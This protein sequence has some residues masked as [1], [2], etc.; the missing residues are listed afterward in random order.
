MQEF[1]TRKAIAQRMDLRLLNCLFRKY[2]MAVRIM[3]LTA[4]LLAACLQLSARGLTQTVTI[5]VKDVPLLTVLK[6][7]KKQTGFV[8]Y[9][10]SEELKR[11]KNV[12]II[13]NNLPLEQVLDLCFKD[14]PLTYSITGKLINI[15]PRIEQVNK[16]NKTSFTAPLP[17]SIDVSGKVM[18]ENGGP[19]AGANVVEKGKQHGTTTNNEGVFVLKGVDENGS[20]EIS[21]IGYQTLTVPINNRTSII[22]SIKQSDASLQEVVINKGYYT[23]QKKLAT[24]NVST[25]KAKDIEMQPVQNPLLTL[26]GRVPGIIVEQKNGFANGGIVVRIQGRNSINSGLD[27][28]YVID[29]V[30]YLSQSLPTVGLSTTVLGNS[31]GGGAGNPLNFINPNDIESI[32]VLKDADATAIYGSRGAN[33]VILITTKKGKAEQ[34]KVSVNARTGWGRVSK[35]VKLLNI[36]QYFEMRKEAYV[37]DGLPIPDKTTIPDNTNYDLTYWDQNRLTDWQKVLIG[38]TAQYKDAQ[39]SVSGGSINTQFLI[40]GGYHKE[41]TVFPDDFADKKASF[42]F[43]INHSSNNQKFKLQA[44]GFYIK[45]DNKIP[46]TDITIYA[47]GLAPNAPALYNPDG[48]L[49]WAPIAQGSGTVSTWVNPL[50]YLYDKYNNKVNN[51]LG[52]A[53]FSYRIFPNLTFSSRFGFNNLQSNDQ[54]LVSLLATRPERQNANSRFAMYGNGSSTSWIVEP[55]LT[56]KIFTGKG[57]IETLLGSSVQQITTKSQ[58]VQA[59]GFSSDLLLEN[60]SSASSLA[61]NSSFYSLYKYNAIFGRV[62]YNY[63]DRYIINFTAR[64]DGSSRFGP[65]NL[66]HN[67]WGIAG[68]WIFTNENWI[69][70]RNS[71]LNFGKVRISY[72][73]T[74]NDQ[75]GD[76]SFMNLYNPLTSGVGISY[77]GVSAM[78]P[79]KLSNPYLQWEETKKLQFGID[80]GLMNDRIIVNLNYYLNRSSNLLAESKVAYITGF[81]S[82]IQNLDGVVE[83]RGWEIS[84]SSINIRKDKF[85]W[86]TNFNVTIPTKNGQLTSF[87]SLSKTNYANTLVVGKS[88]YDTKSYHFIGV[89]PATGLYKYNDTQGNST[90]SPGAKD[91]IA[92]T[93]TT[94]KLYGGLQNNLTYKGVGLDFTFQFVKR[95]AQKFTGT[96]PGIFWGTYNQG[97]QP[98]RVLQRW[99]HPGDLTNV[100]K[101]SSNYSGA[102]SDAEYYY[103]IS[104]AAVTNGSF[105]QLTNLSLSWQFPKL[106]MDKVHFQNCKLF[107][108]GQNL[109]IATKYKGLYPPIGGIVSA[110]PATTLPPL[111]VITI[112]GQITF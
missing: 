73:T 45:D 66:F 110:S 100:E 15:I 93:N 58:S 71:F 37:N 103:S 35:K 18:D 55:Q 46:S 24:G 111:R 6:A 86:V 12:S 92:F 112:G 104:D 30:P 19:L 50:S 59:F 20:L 11:A 107:I 33:G 70:K 2:R 109:F 76:Y 39:I 69:S 80:F 81:N 42:Q 1:A 28:L 9:V 29:G 62:N 63:K 43:N 47:L 44:S 106:W 13:A 10:T 79:T 53:V 49:N 74:G 78:V 22:I 60:L 96:Q 34:T 84:L 41:T 36:D 26:I 85:S 87:P 51:F 89:D 67:F 5:S 77:Q 94:Q 98:E 32:D 25:V 23:E 90:T 72:G 14:Q 4:I 65:E 16:G 102:I 40:S 91:Q 31:G 95:N 27:P 97:N 3:K 88:L 101:F 17:A 83:N 38:G 56:Y 57:K 82:I 54:E 108:Q 105:I 99:Q 48:T 21:Y 68:G 8:F 52:S 64:R 7:I 61:P 75:I